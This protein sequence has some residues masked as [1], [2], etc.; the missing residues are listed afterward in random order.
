MSF[1]LR[2]VRTFHS[3]PG[4]LPAVE[5]D[6]VHTDSRYN[7][8]KHSSGQIDVTVDG[9]CFILQTK[10]VNE[11]LLDEGIDQGPYFDVCY[12]MNSSGKTI[13]TLYPVTNIITMNT[14]SV[15]TAVREQVLHVFTKGGNPA[16]S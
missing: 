14:K 2:F 11:F 5:E 8:Y 16:S 13:D 10:E 3:E 1:H 12:I 6:N 7:V 4:V 15:D 9:T